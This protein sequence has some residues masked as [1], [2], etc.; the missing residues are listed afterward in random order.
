[1]FKKLIIASL[2]LSLIVASHLSPQ[3]RRDDSS[4]NCHENHSCQESM[5]KSFL[6]SLGYKENKG[7]LP[8][9]ILKA[10]IN[11]NIK[12]L[13]KMKFNPNKSLLLNIPSTTTS[14]AHVPYLGIACLLACMEE[15][16]TGEVSHESKLIIQGLIDKGAF[17]GAV[18]VD[19]EGKALA[20]IRDL[21]GLSGCPV[22][23]ILESELKKNYK[24]KHTPHEERLATDAMKHQTDVAPFIKKYLSSKTK[25][26]KHSKN[27][28]GSYDS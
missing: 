22:Y 10:I 16:D 9:T 26:S 13:S 25:S 15:H 11:K 20:S 27:R 12:A 3:K 2:S 21:T 6:G 17:P 7:N 24:K 5:A 19:Q 8:S 23:N 1:M 18:M 4:V 14:P 28:N